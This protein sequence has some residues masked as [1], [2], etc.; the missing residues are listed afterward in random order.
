MPATQPSI[1]R[2]LH[3]WPLL[4]LAILA[5]PLLALVLLLVRPGLQ[6]GARAL[7]LAA[8]TTSTMLATFTITVLGDGLADAAK[9]GHL[10]VN[11]ALAFLIVAAFAAWPTRSASHS[12]PVGPAK[13]GIQR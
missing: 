6:R 1:G 5:L 11:A 8:L 10:V 3:A 13:A 9:Q 7:D 2:V 12:F 4:Q